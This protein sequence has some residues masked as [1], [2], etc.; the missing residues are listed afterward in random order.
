[1]LCESS[2]S[3]GKTENLISF[4]HDGLNI[5]INNPIKMKF[6]GK[7]MSQA[8]EMVW[9]VEQPFAKAHSSSNSVEVHVK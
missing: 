5:L 4:P 9:R 2:A 6:C 7:I 8:L 1:M 3:V